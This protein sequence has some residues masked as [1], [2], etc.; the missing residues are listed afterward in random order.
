[1][2]HTSL[3][4]I[5]FDFFHACADSFRERYIWCSFRAGCLNKGN[6]TSHTFFG[7]IQ[8]WCF[9]IC[10]YQN[11]VMNPNAIGKSI[12]KFNLIMETKVVA[13]SIVF[14]NKYMLIR[15][16]LVYLLTEMDMEARSSKRN[17]VSIQVCCETLQL[18]ISLM[19]PFLLTNPSC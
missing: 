14:Q 2:S 12:P 13:Y 11:E 7:S 5:S 9:P 15:Y 4:W 17:Y 16:I 1:M 10:V 8:I 3:I 18:S 6:Y 19:C